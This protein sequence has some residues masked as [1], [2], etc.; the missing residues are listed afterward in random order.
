MDTTMYN[1]YKSATV[2]Y[3]DDSYYSSYPFPSEWIELFK[4]EKAKGEQKD[5]QFVAGVNIR[6]E[7]VMSLRA[8]VHPGTV[9]FRTLRIKTSMGPRGALSE[10]RK[11]S[12]NPSSAAARVKPLQLPKHD[13]FSFTEPPQRL[14]GRLR[15]A[16]K[17]AEDQEEENEYV[18]AG[19]AGGRA[20]VLGTLATKF[21]KI[22]LELIGE[23]KSRVRHEASASVS[24]VSSCKHRPK[25]RTLPKYGESAA[26]KNNPDWSGNSTAVQL[27]STRSAREIVDY[28]GRHKIKNKD[29]DW[30]YRRKRFSYG[31]AL[32]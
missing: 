14:E 26:A 16:E 24:T 18:P 19:K 31:T 29:M 22:K 4:S 8:I 3:T 9:K 6:Y 11:K 20:T 15:L 30:G 5:D 28:T 1:L 27:S 17:E 10:G 23:L 25:S 12:L 21:N 2:Y 7:P 32:L 13:S